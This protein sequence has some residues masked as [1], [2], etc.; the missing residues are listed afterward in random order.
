MKQNK[1]L[2]K[3][4]CEIW[5]SQNFIS[6]LKTNDDQLIK[7]IDAGTENKETG[8]P[9]FKHARVQIGN[10]TYSGDI[11]IDGVHADWKAHGHH[12]NKKYNS[13]I[14]HVVFN[15]SNYRETYVYT[16]DGRKVQ[17]FSL[18]PFLDESI[19]DKIKKAIVTERSGRINKMPCAEVNQEVPEKE[20][21]DFIYELGIKRFNQKNEKVLSRLKE[22]IYLKELNL[23]EPIVKY[24]PDGEFYQRKF[25][26]KDF[27]DPEIWEQLIYESVFEALGFSKNK[28]I[29]HKLA[30]NV[31]ISYLKKFAA[32]KDFL[33]KLESVFFN[34]SGLMPA[35]DK[36]PDE[37]T[38]EYVR[39]LVEIWSNNKAGYD[40]RVFHQTQW[41]FAKLRPYN[42]PTI[43]IAGGVRLICQ[44]IR[45]KIINSIIKD[46]ENFNSNKQLISALR[47]Y[48]IIKGDGFWENHYVF[49]QPANVKINYFVGVSRADEIIINVLLPV[50]SVYF[51]IFDKRFLQKKFI[52]FI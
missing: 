37:E 13:V 51:E 10:L 49:D 2:E 17:S 24:E 50:F 25:E 48:L 31:N 12:L 20:K 32:D 21:L 43:R 36:M 4:L 30:S 47:G 40:G 33:L 46:F 1:I 26:Q 52:K 42:F 19:N 28:D 41:N 39:Q 11:E 14:L 3:F 16:Q 23:K 5:K 8:A 7:I 35:G 45:G 15:G 18:E 6:E 9:D 29:M 38:A 27:N 22:L 44:L 34:I